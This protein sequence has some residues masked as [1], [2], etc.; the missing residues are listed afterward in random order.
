MKQEEFELDFK[1]ENKID[2]N[3][4][5]V[6][7]IFTFLRENPIFDQ[8]VIL[9]IQALSPLSFVSST[10]GD[11]Y[12][13]ANK[14]S[15]HMIW[16]MLENAIGL[17]LTDKERKNKNNP[18]VKY[19]RKNKELNSSNSGYISLLQHHVKIIEIRE[20]YIE[21]YVDLFCQHL[22][23]SDERHTK[24]SRFFD[25]HYVS[26]YLDAKTKAG[27]KKYLKYF[28]QYYISQAKREYLIPRGAYEVHI[29]TSMKLVGC[30]EQALHFPAAPLYL[31]NSDGWIEVE[32][33]RG[34]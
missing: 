8:K 17:H 6:N 21:R 22:R 30:I 16:G 9:K 23:G 3:C 12:H 31:G 14:P 10:P 29:Q 4:D 19:I 11:I 1:T 25:W 20:P 32:C 2:A 5:L 34:G 7:N 13:S 27:S 24:G 26:H 15:E 28:P 18:Y 33:E